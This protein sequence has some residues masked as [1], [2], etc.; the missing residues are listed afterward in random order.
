VS[1]PCLRTRHNVN[2]LGDASRPT[3]LLAHGFGCSQAMWRH[4][5]QD[6]A[7]DHH[8]VLFDHIGAG[9]ADPSAYDRAR[10]ADL[11]GYG[12]DVADLIEALELT[13]VV[14]VGHSVSSMIGVLASQLTDR[15]GRL[16]LVGPSP[17]YLDDPATGYV[18]GFDEPSIAE[19]LDLLDRNHVAFAAALAPS[20]I[21]NADR[22]ELAAELQVSVCAADPV[23]TRRFARATFLGDNRADLA[24]VPV[25]TLVLQCARDVI[26]PPAVGGYVA[27]H[28]PD[29]QLVTLDVEGHAPN[30][31]DP[32]LTADA[33][34]GFVAGG[35]ASSA[36]PATITSAV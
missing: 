6:L 23:V 3:L 31:S 26:A 16:V 8:V 21:G 28:I 20:V 17:R 33:I 36:V 5:A 2:E 27:T 13:D 10:H 15:I 35:T 25:P 29:A 19:L 30:L 32:E 11:S 34:R 24:A 14:Y 7:R 12:Q 18:G 22:P 1:A 4:V 9:D